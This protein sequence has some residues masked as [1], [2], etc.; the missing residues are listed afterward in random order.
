MA[1]FLASLKTLIP[2]PD[3]IS[4]VP[5]VSVTKLLLSLFYDMLAV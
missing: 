3:S 1:C 4:P 2:Q 5:Y